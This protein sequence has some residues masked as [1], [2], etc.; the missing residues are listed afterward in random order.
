[1]DYC[2][3]GSIKDLI[4]TG[5]EPLDEEQIKFVI[6]NAVKALTY[7]HSQNIIHRDVKAANI[8]LNERGE[9]K[10]GKIHAIIKLIK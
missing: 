7:L 1:M 4:L 5:E 10:I 2:A 6:F 9:V 8:L 3:L